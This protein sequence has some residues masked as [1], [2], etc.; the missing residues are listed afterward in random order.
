MPSVVSRPLLKDPFAVQPR[1]GHY[2]VLSGDSN[3]LLRFLE[4]GAVSGVF[5]SS[6]ILMCPMLS[7]DVR[8]HPKVDRSTGA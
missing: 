8:L 2:S 1:P 4:V 3:I 7:V 5:G 6:L